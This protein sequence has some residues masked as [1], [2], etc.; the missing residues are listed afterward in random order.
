[1]PMLLTVTGA[2][3]SRLPITHSVWFGGATVSPVNLRTEVNHYQ[4]S[5]G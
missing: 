2:I 1:M 4:Y 5:V 3:L